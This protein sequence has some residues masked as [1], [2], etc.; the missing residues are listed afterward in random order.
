MLWEIIL[1]E[2]PIDY[3][4]SCYIV[5]KNDT[6]RKEI[7][8]QW[9]GFAYQFTGRWNYQYYVGNSEDIKVK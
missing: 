2:E 5:N 6:K 3:S 1:I 8:F 9:K 4:W 7:S